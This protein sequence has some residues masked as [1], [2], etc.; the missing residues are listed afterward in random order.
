MACVYAP[1]TCADRPA[2]FQQ[3]LHQVL[4][5]H[6]NLLVG[7]D[8][9]CILDPLDVAGC[10]VGSRA[11]GAAEL[12]QQQQTFQLVDIWRQQHANQTD[13]TFVHQQG[14]AR[15]DRWLITNQL[16]DSVTACAIVNGFATDHLGVSIDIVPPAARYSGPGLW[17][18]PT[19]LLNDDDMVQATRE[20]MIAWQQ[21]YP[22]DACTDHAMRW[23]QFKQYTAGFLQQQGSKRRR[24]QRQHDRLQQHQLAAT[25]AAYL[26]DPTDPAKLQRWKHAHQ[27]LQ[28]EVAG[29]ASCG[30]IE[31]ALH[32][33]CMVNSPPTTSTTLPSS[34]SKQLASAASR[35]QR[36]R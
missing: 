13:V 34:A 27:L 16:S 9:N 25:K 17:R 24:Q 4:P 6:C 23:V 14:S 35:P 22:A 8:F 11:R 2:F 33:T 30:Q 36:L 21:Q 10:A 29:N 18:L 31:Q 7:G 20:A 3:Q 5:H 15:L 28:E 32:G 12:Q 1:C 26:A 19:H